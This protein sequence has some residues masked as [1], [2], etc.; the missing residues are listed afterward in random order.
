MTTIAQLPN[1]IL[2]EVFEWMR[3]GNGDL[4]NAMKTCRRWHHLA[5]TTVYRHITMCSKLRDDTTTARFAASATQCDLVQSFSLNITQVHLMGFSI[6][7][8]DA[9]DRLVELCNAVSSMRNLQT[10][11]LSFEKAIGQGFNVS[12]AT[13]VQLLQS[14]P[15][16]VVNLNLDCECLDS[17]DLGQP[18]VCEAVSALLPRLRSL[19]LRT[20]HLC[21]G[22]FVHHAPQETRDLVR[23]P[24]FPLAITQ[25]NG[26]SALE[27]LLICLVLRPESGSASHTNL[28]FAGN[29]PMQGARLS[30]ALCDLQKAGVFP[31]LRKFAVV[32]R[33]DAPSTPQHDNWNVFKIRYMT[34]H[35]MTT[36][37][38]PWCARGGSSSLYMVR[39]EEEDWFGSFDEITS[40]LE[41][42]MSWTKVGIKSRVP[43]NR[44]RSGWQLNR[45]RLA[46]RTSV[47]N[48]FGVS[49]RLWKHEE[50]ANM[51]LL[52]ARTAPGFDDTAALCQ[53]V[54]DGWRWV[55]EGPW[56]W[57][58]AAA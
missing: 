31:S 3:D 13:I 10:F 15:S 26:T 30:S 8:F 55:P 36:S 4:V 58:I 37:T 22:L 47:I 35:L 7:S 6:L 56:D 5:S 54:P 44:S 48:K 16:T 33:V 41:G 39:D 1:E 43:G 18:H 23:R 46:S 29:R 24:N 52:H 45:S 2:L 12:G 17:P 51:Q 21:A 14:L 27:Y 42:S 50:A 40:A 53:I 38:L 57:T 11:A 28:C 20:S 49:F 25:V 19:R 34:K 32:G 9:F